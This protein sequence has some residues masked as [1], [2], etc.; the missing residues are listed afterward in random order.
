MCTSLEMIVLTGD[1]FYQ[2][3][4]P[5]AWQAVTFILFSRLI[6]TV[7]PLCGHLLE[8][9]YILVI[10]DWLSLLFAVSGGVRV[11]YLQDKSYS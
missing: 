3:L 2:L 6:V 5:D 7:L 9:P 4:H 1:N 11:L 10:H 8:I